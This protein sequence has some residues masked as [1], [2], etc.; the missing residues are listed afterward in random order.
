MVSSIK[1]LQS[2][3][4]EWNNLKEGKI[5]ELTKPNYRWWN[6]KI[7]KFKKNDPKKDSSQP[8][9]THQTHDLDHETKITL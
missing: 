1:T 8:T 6:W 3:S 7:L 5:K 2:R 9:L 4:C